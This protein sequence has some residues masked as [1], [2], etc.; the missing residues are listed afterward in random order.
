MAPNAAV[1]IRTYYHTDG[2]RNYSQYSTE[3]SDE[4]A[5]RI[6]AENDFETRKALVYEWEERY[7]AE[8]APHILLFVVQD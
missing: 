6:L 5:D 4:L 2:G 7:I 3:W 8:G 1:E